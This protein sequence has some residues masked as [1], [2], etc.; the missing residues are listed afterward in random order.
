MMK[1]LKNLFLVVLMLSLNIGYGQECAC[2]GIDQEQN[3]QQVERELEI[4]YIKQ[5]NQVWCWIAVSTMA[6]NYLNSDQ[7]TQC[8]IMNAYIK[9]TGRDIDCCNNSAKECQRPGQTEEVMK[10][11]TQNQLYGA[12][13]RASLTF[14]GVKKHID[15]DNI[16]IMGLRS[17]PQMGHVVILAGY[18]EEGQKI[19]ILD[20]YKN[21]KVANYNEYMGRS[22]VSWAETILASKSSLDYLRQDNRD[23]NRP[24]RVGHPGMRANSLLSFNGCLCH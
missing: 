6:I 19:V 1:V 18:E 12:S 10:I 15:S 5:Q 2:K 11:L 21:R 7:L 8:E 20:P 3:E 13:S 24:L 14:S 16:I 4:D 9:T 22:Q 17:G 23:F